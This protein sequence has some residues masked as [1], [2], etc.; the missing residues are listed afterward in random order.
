[1]LKIAPYAVAGVADF[2]YPLTLDKKIDERKHLTAAEV[3]KLLA[4][5]KGSR[6]AARDRCLL[7]LM[8]YKAFA[9]TR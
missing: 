2:S 1:M 5:T 9:A 3:E 4:A 6:N 8:P 7:L